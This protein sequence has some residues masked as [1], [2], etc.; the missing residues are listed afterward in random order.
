MPRDEI[1]NPVTDVEREAVRTAQRALSVRETGLLDD[2]TKASLRGIQ[3]LL[4]LPVTGVLDRVTAD[5]LERLRPPGL[6]E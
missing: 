2:V 1:L 4:G 6:R 3:R 5:A